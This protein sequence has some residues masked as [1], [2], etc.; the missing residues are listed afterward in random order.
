MYQSCGVGLM[1]HL[2]GSAG[3]VPPCKVGTEKTEGDEVHETDKALEVGDTSVDG[4]RTSIP[5]GRQC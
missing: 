3:V 2:N 4:V 5:A 1:N